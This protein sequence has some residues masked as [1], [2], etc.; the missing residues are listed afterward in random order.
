MSFLI[1]DALRREKGGSY[2]RGQKKANLLRTVISKGY[3][4]ASAYVIKIRKS[5]TTCVKR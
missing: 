2:Q 3:S 5:D 4:L 1:S